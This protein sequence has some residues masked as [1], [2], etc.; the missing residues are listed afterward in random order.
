[1]QEFFK[2]TFSNCKILISS[3]SCR[4]GDLRQL[5][6][7]K[8]LRRDK[9]TVT[10]KFKSPMFRSFELS[11]ALSLPSAETHLLVTRHFQ[12]QGSFE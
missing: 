4:S 9:K 10:E 7:R 2:N 6:N 12:C 11:K 5:G 1:V 8:S 3:S